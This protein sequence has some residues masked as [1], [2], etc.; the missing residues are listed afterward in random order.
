MVQNLHFSNTEQL[1]SEIYQFLLPNRMKYNKAET[2]KLIIAEQH[3]HIHSFVS[4]FC[5]LTLL[6][7]I[8][9]SVYSL[10]L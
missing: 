10:S 8:W 6:D 7:A 5:V 9:V 3:D 4:L 2:Q 1:D